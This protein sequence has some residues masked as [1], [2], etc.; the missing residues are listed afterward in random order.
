MVITIREVV[1]VVTGHSIDAV[2]NGASVSSLAS[3]SKICFESGSASVEV[4]HDVGV[5][6]PAFS[7]DIFQSGRELL[8]WGELAIGG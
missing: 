6:G 8:E 4:A 1:N 7:E 5:V 2:V 3:A